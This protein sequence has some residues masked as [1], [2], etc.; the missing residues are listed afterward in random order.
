MQEEARRHEGTKAQ[1]DIEYASLVQPTPLRVEAVQPR[2]RAWEVYLLLLVLS[3]AAGLRVARITY[4]SL[5]F[6]EI[7]HLELSTGRGSP[8]VRVPENQLIPNAPDVTSLRGSDVP[9]FY[10]VWSHMDFVV[11]P[12]LYVTLL[13]L[14]RDVFGDGDI[15]ARLYSIFCSLAA[16][17]FMFLAARE[18]NGALVALCAAA[19]YAVAP[20]QI[21][22][23]QQVRG[24]DQL[25]AFGM[26]AAFCLVR[27]EMGRGSIPRNA[28]ALGVCTLGMMLSHYFAAGACAAIG[29]YVLLRLRGRTLRV[30]LAALL[31]SAVAFVLIWGPFLWKQR[32]Y[33]AQTADVWLM[34]RTP[35][36]LINTAGRLFSWC[37][38]LIV[39]EPSPSTPIA[40]LSGL[41]LIIPPIAIV[42]RRRYELLLWYLWL[43][44][45]LGFV[46]SLDFVRSTSH[47][48]YERYVS[49][50]SPA[51]FVLLAAM[52][53]RLPPKM[54]KNIWMIVP[55][56]VVAISLY[57]WRLGY[58]TEGEPDW[59]QLGFDIDQSVR[60]GETI[61]FYPGTQP[62]WYIE[63]FYL[64][65]SHYSHAFPRPIIK[66][67]AP[68]TPELVS[69]IPG[70][71][72]WM[73][74]GSLN[75]S[76]DP[77]QILPGVTV[78]E[79]HGYPIL[80]HVE[81]PPR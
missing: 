36:H 60:P 18:L 41:L 4:G 81:L 58:V 57:D 77:A 42:L 17:T 31:A 49:L 55:A 45:T 24:Y 66:L 15:A 29:V 37:W 63:I 25:V 23:A 3:I 38:W 12:P 62:K 79:Q 8:H 44:G 78:V 27:L 16:I 19:M 11:H 5:S 71:S 67:S 74:S 59:R 53:A 69:Q 48:R 1:R 13:R 65:A 54:P 76:H 56:C 68:A 2:L 39:R 7:W 64:A 43:L 72:A 40:M 30:T 34:E 61:I 75:R 33:F 21:F 70:N 26:A 51:V 20:T 10:A 35:D 80:T 50:A 6:D 47:L 22:L 46:A 28:I 52:A 32:T 73:V 14:W 9:P